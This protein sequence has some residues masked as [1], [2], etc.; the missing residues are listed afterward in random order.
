MLGLLAL[1]LTAVM[2]FTLV[3]NALIGV[4]LSADDKFNGSVDLIIPITKTSE[5][6]LEPWI[7]NLTLLATQSTT[8]RIHVLIDDDHPALVAWQELHQKL[9]NV[10]I[11]HFVS[12]PLSRE[13]VP[14]MIEQIFPEIQGDVVIIGDS[15][16]VPT[17]FAFSS[18]AKLVT[19]KRKAY[20][21]L[22]QTEKQN[23][24]AEAIACVN[25]TLAFASIYGFRRLR[26]NIS[27]PLISISQGWMA[28][29]LESFRQFNWAKVNIYSWKEAIA[30]VW[31]IENKSYLIAFG[32]KH[33]LRH[34]PETLQLQT[35]ALLNYWDELWHRGSRTGLGL[36]LVALFIWSFPVFCFFSHPFW[37]LAS[38]F[39]LLLYRFFTKIV[40]QESWGAMILHPVSTLIW[41]GTFLWWALS[42]LKNRYASQRPGA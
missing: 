2:I 1:G 9:A 3:K 30:M 17:Q 26:R 19:E 41:V 23:P 27:H 18:V 24:L 12:T 42:G 15:E 6:Y 5:F 38:I 8:V 39:L 40:F 35:Q 31:N 29:P 16:L 28:M 14:W 25:P 36:Y 10:Q 11:H 37:S 32:E 34:Y 21:V 33:L 7:K 13:S 20:F 4:Q 22:P